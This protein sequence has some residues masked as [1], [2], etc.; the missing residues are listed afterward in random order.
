MSKWCPNCKMYKPGSEFY[1]RQNRIDSWCIN[2]VTKSRR[3]YRASSNGKKAH[4]K[5][6]RNWMLK[7]KYG[8]TQKG[9]DNLL[10]KQ[11]GQ[12]ALCGSMDTGK[13]GINHFAVDHC[14]ITGKVRGLLCNNCNRALGLFKEDPITLANAVE[15]VLGE[16]ASEYVE[17]VRQ[18]VQLKLIV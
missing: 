6:N 4:A 7:S 9:Y 16:N 15:Y 12:C 10:E 17:S 8:I 5:V 13:K 3:E 18:S 2:C 11:H 14:H 1:K